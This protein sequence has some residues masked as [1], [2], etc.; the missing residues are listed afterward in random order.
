M[1]QERPWVVPVVPDVAGKVE[2]ELYHISPK[3]TAIPGDSIL[4]LT[5][6]TITAPAQD[7]A[8]SPGYMVMVH[9]PG[10]HSQTALTERAYP[11]LLLDDRGL[12]YW[13]LTCRQSVH[14]LPGP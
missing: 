13:H 14:I 9:A 12:D 1:I 5:F 2:Q 7:T 6:C 8:Y 3:A 4:D 11:S 10:L